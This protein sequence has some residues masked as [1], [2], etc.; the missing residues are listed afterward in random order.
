MGVNFLKN[1]NSSLIYNIFMY[2]ITGLGNPGKKYENN[3]HNV[4]FMFVDYLAKKYEAPP[5][6]ELKYATTEVTDAKIKSE[7]LTLIKPQTY[8]NNSGKSVRYFFIKNKDL[9]FDNL[10]VTHDDLDIPLGKF[11]IQKSVGPKLHNGLES[12]EN[13]IGTADFYRI[14]I[15][16]DNRGETKIPGEAYVLQNFTQAE[17]DTLND[18]FPTIRSR[19][20][21]EFLHTK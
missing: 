10:F 2:L 12:I 20:E 6:K 3:R 16:V 1:Y 4:G 8:M 21:S 18:I 17:F 19:L 5:F 9:H 7:A 13:A 11:K 14:R 15:G